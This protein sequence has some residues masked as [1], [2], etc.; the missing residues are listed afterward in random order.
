MR[1]TKI[2]ISQV[3]AYDRTIYPESSTD[4]RDTLVMFAL[5]ASKKLGPRWSLIVSGDVTKNTSSDETTYSYDRFTV[6]AGVGYNF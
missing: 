6:N 1:F 5:L 2:D 4:R 3:L